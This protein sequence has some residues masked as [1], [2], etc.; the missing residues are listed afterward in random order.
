MTFSSFI[1][2]AIMTFLVARL[3]RPPL[4]PD[5]NTLCGC[6]TS[7]IQQSLLFPPNSFVNKANSTDNKSSSSLYTLQ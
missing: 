7:E 6:I 2:L 3:S 5:P 1:C 4:N